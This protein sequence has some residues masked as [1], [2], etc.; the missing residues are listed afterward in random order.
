MSRSVP[1]ID[2]G[3]LTTVLWTLGI[4][5]PTGYP[6]WTLLGFLFVHIPTFGEVV[7]R[8]NLFATVC[9]SLS[10]AMF[11][12]AFL[13]MQAVLT[14]AGKR[15]AEPKQSKKSTANVPKGHLLADEKTSR[16][17]AFAAALT[18]AFSLTFWKQATVVETYSLELFLFAAIITVWLGFYDLPTRSRSYF[19]G[20]VLGLGFTNHMTTVLTIPAI[21]FLLVSAYRRR[22]FKLQ[23]LY[24]VILGG[25]TA[26]LIYLYLPIRA[27]QAPLMDWGN[28]DTLKRFYWQVSAKQFRTWMF[29]SLDVFERQ[30]GVF[31]SSIYPDFRISAVVV[32]IGVATSFLSRR[33]FFWFTILLVVGD[34]TYASNYN[35]H[36]IH[37]YFL[38]AFI[39]FAAFGL[40]GYSFLVQRMRAMRYGKAAAL[41]LIFPVVSA[42]SN[43]GGPNASNDYAVECYSHDILTS[44]PKNSVI[45]SF[46]WDIFVAGSIYYQHVD[47]VRTDVTVIDKELLRRSWYAAEV[48][49]RYPFLFPKNDQVYRFY[50]DNLRLFE[51][52]L[53]YDPRTIQRSYSDYIREIILG[54]L[55]HGRK[56]FVGP[57]IQNKYLYGF[58]KVPYGLLFELTPDTTYVPFSSRG[59]NGYRGAQKLDNPYSHQILNFYETMFMARAGYEYTH[60]HLRLTIQWIDKAL[61]V[62]PSSQQAQTAKAQLLQEL[63]RVR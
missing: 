18:L 4:A 12:L 55:R 1:Y 48:H 2:G 19:A 57:E 51:N 60:K 42:F 41:I 50:R 7:A 22:K 36:N 25:L 34:V 28:P 21:L 52:N 13:R 20:L 31:A 10:T 26:A 29:S 59:L 5:H 14:P 37:S 38:L 43:F 35:I 3:E 16:L 23:I 15:S 56:I 39:G 44:V 32:I 45:L 62:D 33:R 61:A 24:F 58:N 49:S 6:L 47:D 11:Y 53:P 54:A 9:T 17:P 30:L 46:Q 63:S 8:A 27:S 40:M